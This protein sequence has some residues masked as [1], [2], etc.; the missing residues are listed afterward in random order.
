VLADDWCFVKSR[1]SSNSPSWTTLFWSIFCFYGW[2]YLNVL[3]Y[4]VLL[5]VALRHIYLLK[6]SL[7]IN[8]VAL[9]K[10]ETSIYKLVWYPLITLV[11]WLPA[12]IHDVTELNEDSSARYTSNSAQ[13][14]A[15][16]LPTTHGIF[17]CCAF[18]ATNTD[19]RLVLTELF[20]FRGWPDDTLLETLI[21]AEMTMRAAATDR[22][23]R[24]SDSRGTA[25]T[26]PMK[27]KMMSPVPVVT[28]PLGW[29]ADDSDE[30]TSEDPYI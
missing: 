9:N 26:S 17:I 2:L 25:L 12:A 7:N 18:F 30:G 28:N 11:V 27:K 14:F 19:V 4:I 1:A 8:S 10:M 29:T 6:N 22:S 16:L 3:V 21:S 15:Y 23:S 5:C 24:G 13:Y 20:Q